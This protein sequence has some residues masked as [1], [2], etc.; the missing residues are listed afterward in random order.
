MEEAQKKASAALKNGS[1]EINGTMELSLPIKM[2]DETVI[3]P[4]IGFI[5]GVNF[6]VTGIGKFE[7][8][9]H[10][11]STKRTISSNG[12]SISGEVSKCI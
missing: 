1:K 7:G 5:A 11:T 12:L 3:N 8:K 6:D 10:L 4:V 9:Y 2:K